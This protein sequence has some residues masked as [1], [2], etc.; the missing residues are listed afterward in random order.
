MIAIT[1]SNSIKMKFVFFD[2][3]ERVGSPAATAIS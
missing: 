3:I 2:E 1:T